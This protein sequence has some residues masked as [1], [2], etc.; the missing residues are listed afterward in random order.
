MKFLHLNSAGK[1]PG[2]L[3]IN[4]DYIGMVLSRSKQVLVGMNVRI[5]REVVGSFKAGTSIGLHAKDFIW[6]KTTRTWR[7]CGL[8]A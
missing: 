8:R 6:K 4:S 5:R 3:N 2:N 1:V 7:N